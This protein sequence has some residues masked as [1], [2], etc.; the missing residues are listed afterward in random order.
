MGT[1]LGPCPWPWAPPKGRAHGY[2]GQFYGNVTAPEAVTKL[3]Q[4]YYYVHE[5]CMG[6]VRSGI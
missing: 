6:L 3:V 1:A 2:R 4:T 5:L